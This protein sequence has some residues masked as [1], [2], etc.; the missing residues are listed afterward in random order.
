MRA[1]FS[2]LIFEIFV[3]FHIFVFIDMIL[4]FAP[5]QDAIINL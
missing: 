5:E 3:F 2:K 1:H 4:L